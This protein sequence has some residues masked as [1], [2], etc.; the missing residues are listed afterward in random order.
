[1]IYF[2]S[3]FLFALVLLLLLSTFML[4][5]LRTTL[6]WCI[7]HMK[8]T[9][10]IVWKHFVV[11]GRERKFVFIAFHLL[12]IQPEEKRFWFF[13]F[14]FLF[15]RIF[16]I[17]IRT[18]LFVV[19]IVL[20]SLVFVDFY[21]ACFSFSTSI[22]FIHVILKFNKAHSEWE[23]TKRSAYMAFAFAA[24]ALLF[25]LRSHLIHCNTLHEL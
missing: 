15:V 6:H 16:F 11:Y 19:C 2:F 25:R 13:F 1:M 5:L 3:L 7:G 8:I 14:L 18:V 24:A 22:V 23:M 9:H 10:C 17:S 12:D 4:F 21:A 20:C